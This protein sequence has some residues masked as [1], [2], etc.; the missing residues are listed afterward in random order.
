V[1]AALE[2]TAAVPLARKADWLL[3][4]AWLGRL[5]SRLLLPAAAASGELAEAGEADQHARA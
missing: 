2:H 3:M 1:G 4:A 5:R